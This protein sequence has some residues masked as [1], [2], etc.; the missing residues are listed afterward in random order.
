S[1]SDAIR[2]GL[3]PAARTSGVEAA[4]EIPRRPLLRRARRAGGAGRSGGEG[5]RAGERRQADGGRRS[6]DD[7]DGG[8]SGN[9]GEHPGQEKEEEK[10]DGSS[11]RAALV[12]NRLPRRADR[13]CRLGGLAPERTA[14]VRASGKADGKPGI[15]RLD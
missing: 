11:L 6:D 14:V 12:F 5:G 8:R 3:S 2:V 13:A 4:G 9:F 1:A 15:L 7:A 10:E